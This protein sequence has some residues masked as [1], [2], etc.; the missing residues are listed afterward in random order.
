MLVIYYSVL[1]V[2]LFRLHLNIYVITQ[3]SVLESIT[4]Q[5]FV[6]YK[7]ISLGVIRDTEVHIHMH[8]QY[9]STH[10]STECGKAHKQNAKQEE[11][12]VK[13]EEKWKQKTDFPV[14]KPAS[15]AEF[16]VS[17]CLL[18]VLILLQVDLPWITSFKTLCL[19]TYCAEIALHNKFHGSWHV[20]LK[21]EN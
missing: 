21:Q 12:W 17:N 3:K 15:W 16:S 2:S 1:C 7:N 5:R 9:A 14:D 4:R 10:A 13:P 18:H 20:Q 11:K 19:H 8:R 6:E